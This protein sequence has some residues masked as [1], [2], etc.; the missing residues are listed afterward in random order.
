ML[1]LRPFFPIATTMQSLLSHVCSWSGGRRKMEIRFHWEVWSP[2]SPACIQ[3]SWSVR[4]ISWRFGMLRPPRVRAP[5]LVQSVRFVTPCG[6]QS[7]F[8]VW[9]RRND[10]GSRLL[11]IDVMPF[12]FWL[13]SFGLR[14]LRV[15]SSLCPSLETRTLI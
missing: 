3:T 15:D 13:L 1:S 8:Q 10:H 9:C 12:S 6:I 4:H 5:F 2:F 11:T 7:T 14:P